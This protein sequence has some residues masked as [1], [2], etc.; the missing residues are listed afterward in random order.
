MCVK[1]V[2]GEEGCQGERACELQ[3]YN[4]HLGLKLRLNLSRLQDLTDETK[5]QTL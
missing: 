5:F 1:G 3:G 4:S 2:G